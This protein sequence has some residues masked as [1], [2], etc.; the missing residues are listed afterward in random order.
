MPHFID[1]AYGSNASRPTPLPSP[2]CLA[3][4]RG[5]FPVAVQSAVQHSLTETYRPCIWHSF[6]YCANSMCCSWKLCKLDGLFVANAYLS[7]IGWLVQ[8]CDSACGHDC[9]GCMD[10]GCLRC[11]LRREILPAHPLWWILLVIIFLNFP[12]FKKLVIFWCPAVSR[13]DVGLDGGEY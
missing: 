11:F 7:A 1:G 5:C 4:L 2:P 13:C 12:T 9:M 10:H 8:Q 3:L 6:N